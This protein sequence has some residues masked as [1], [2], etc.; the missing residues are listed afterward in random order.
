MFFKIFSNNRNK[1]LAEDFLV[2]ILS[3]VAAIFIAKVGFVSSLPGML[4]GYGYIGI[5]IAGIGFTS[6][7]TTAPALTILAAFAGETDPFAVAV[8]GGL[9]ATF[10]DYVIFKFVKGRVYDDIKYIIKTI[11]L[12]RHKAIFNTRL[13]HFFTPF[14]GALIIS[15]PFP[16]E[17]GLTILGFSKIQT[18]IFLPLLFV[19]NAVGIILITSIINI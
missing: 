10:G 15:S 7:F 9:G 17:I 16:D 5:L 6:I 14:V 1:Q 19:L 11:H 3:I 12:K 8:L 18:N 4:G 13:F 2:I